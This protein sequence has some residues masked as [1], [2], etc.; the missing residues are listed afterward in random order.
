MKSAIFKSMPLAIVLFLATVSTS[1]AVM[2]F[3]PEANYNKYIKYDRYLDVEIWVDND[4]FY[5]GDDI[6]I[7]FRANKDCYVAI[8][9]IDS[10]G[11][12]NLIFPYSPGDN[13]RIESNSIYR[14]P[15]SH[16]SYEL[17]VQGPEGVEYLQVVAS[18][19]PFPI[20]DWFGGS[21][22]VC[23][24]DPYDFM[25]YIN[26]NYFGGEQDQPRAFDLTSFVVRDWDQYYFR[27]QH[28]QYYDPWDWGYCGGVYVD[29]PFGATIYIDGIYW[30]IAPLFIPRIYFGWHYIT[31]YDHNGWCWEDRINVVRHR[32]LVLDQ[33]IVRT[34]VG[35]KSRFKEVSRRGYL[36]PVANGYPN[37]D[38][39]VK[40]KKEYKPVS[41][42]EGEG[43]IKYADDQSTRAIRESS[44]K[45]RTETMTKNNE[46]YRSTSRTSNKASTRESSTRIEKQRSTEKD[47]DYSTQ[48]TYRTTKNDRSSGATESKTYEKTNSGSK[49]SGT[50]RSKSS[51]GSSRVTNKSG[52]GG[53]SA[54]ATT[55]TKSGGNSGGGAK[56]RGK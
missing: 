16:D 25:D 45:T 55:R 42:I 23:N 19:Q 52:G 28:V 1:V 35:V 40:V 15:D 26:A 53:S 54:G 37:Y 17:T 22:I 4:A 39:Q 3:D 36:N 49:S 33:S 24:D 2:T 38:A 50:Q 20:P 21:G 34:K 14:I 30:G 11:Q 44:Y 12:V 6:N 18:T 41:R 31:I 27:P 10:R 7:S 46:T 48:R 43:R 56:E 51:A 9:N 32:S 29:Y 13:N 8:Y 47:R 5:A